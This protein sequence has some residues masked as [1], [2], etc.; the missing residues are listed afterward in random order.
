MRI[1]AEKLAKFTW[2]R[3]G[4]HLTGLSDFTAYITSHHEFGL[5]GLRMVGNS[6]VTLER[7][8]LAGV[9]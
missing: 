1:E 4:G 9:G 3:C 5:N 8:K 6:G 7:S 2:V